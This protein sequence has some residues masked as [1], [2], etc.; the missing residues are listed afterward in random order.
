[1][2]EL[3]EKLKGKV[4]IA[5]VGNPL[6]GDD[7]IGNLIYENLKGKIKATLINCEESPEKFL[8]TI[9]NENPDTVIF[10][11]SVISG[12]KPGTIFLVREQELLRLSN[13]THRLP[14]G[15]SIH[16]I[17]S[18]IPCEVLLIGIES[19]NTEFGAKISEEVLDS[20]KA[21]VDFLVENL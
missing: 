16:Y 4:L 5:T 17:K 6:R 11:D 1:M 18:Q 14:L 12:S 2:N 20:A 9:V 3:V 15:M 7:G 8:D 21:I 13:S 19:K 10:I